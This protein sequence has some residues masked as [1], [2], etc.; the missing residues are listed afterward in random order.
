VAA[1]VVAGLSARDRAV[2]RWWLRKIGKPMLTWITFPCY[3]VMFSLMIYL[4]GY[5]CAQVKRSSTNCTW[6][7]CC[8]MATT[9]SCA[10]DLRLDLLASQREIFRGQQTEA[11]DLP[12]RTRGIERRCEHGQFSR[13]AEG[14]Q[15]RGGRF[16]AGV[17]KPALC[18]RLVAGAA[19]RG[20]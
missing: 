18:E 2:D 16:C 8:A 7:T 20:T 5:K 12:R 13:A 10:A 9:R 17:D 11:G 14:R 19:L 4:I 1:D 15:F 6:W 3:V